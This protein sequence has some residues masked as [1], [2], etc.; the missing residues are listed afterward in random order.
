MSNATPVP[1]FDHMELRDVGPVSNGA[2]SD[3][4]RTGN[5]DEG[6]RPDNRR[7]AA[8][9]GTDDALMRVFPQD[10]D[11]FIGEVASEIARDQR[12]DEGSDFQMVGGKRRPEMNVIAGRLSFSATQATLARFRST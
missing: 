11:A 1:V 7:Q 8:E 4:P 6:R 2:K 3:D 10:R 5:R 12:R 9:L